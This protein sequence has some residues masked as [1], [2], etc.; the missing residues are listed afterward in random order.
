MRLEIVTQFVESVR[1]I[2]NEEFSLGL[3]V[4]VEGLTA[5]GIVGC[6]DFDDDRRTAPA[7]IEVSVGAWGRVP[8]AWRTGPILDW[9]LVCTEIVRAPDRLYSG[10]GDLKRECLTHFRH[11]GW[12]ARAVEAA[13]ADGSYDSPS[14]A[15]PVRTAPSED[16]S[17]D[18]LQRPLRDL[19]FD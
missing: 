2:V 12:I 16:Q 3:F 1:E 8:K 19:A 6:V 5:K 9:L 11:D 14:K 17:L 15:A 18:D 10:L 13:N 7:R 4:N